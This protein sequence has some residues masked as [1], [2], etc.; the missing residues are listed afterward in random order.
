MS[1]RYPDDRL[2]RAAAD[3]DLDQK[4]VKNTDR[5]VGRGGKLR[6]G[7]ELKTAVRRNGT[8]AAAGALCLRRQLEERRP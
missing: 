5:E 8:G 3:E 7:F 2:A 1:A 6:A 4:I